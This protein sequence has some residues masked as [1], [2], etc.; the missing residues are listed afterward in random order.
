MSKEL[1]SS[2]S[3]V[4]PGPLTI[5]QRCF[6]IEDFIM[7]SFNEMCSF[8]RISR[9]STRVLRSV[10]ENLLFVSFHV[11]CFRMDSRTSHSCFTT[12]ISARCI[13]ILMGT[14]LALTEAL[15]VFTESQSDPIIKRYCPVW[16]GHTST[17]D[18]LGKEYDQI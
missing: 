3:C 12:L 11:T 18:A 9:Y 10:G 17:W 7:D 2:L 4:R 16:A 8:G 15:P 13:D 14:A 1:T 5:S 6:D